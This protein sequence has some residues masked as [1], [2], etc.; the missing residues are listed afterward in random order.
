MHQVGFIYKIDTVCCINSVPT[1]H[2]THSLFMIYTYTSR[3]MLCRKSTSD[4][5]GNKK[6]G[7][8]RECHFA[9]CPVVTYTCRSLLNLKQLMCHYISF[10]ASTSLAFHR[11][12]PVILK[13]LVLD[14]Q[15]LTPK[16]VSYSI[17]SC[18]S[19]VQFY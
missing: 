13:P 15:I 2:S 11:V 14:I 7:V 4:Y 9:E 5:C 19:S 12:C 1:S 6:T 18:K 3:L 17:N 16:S 10:C 8:N